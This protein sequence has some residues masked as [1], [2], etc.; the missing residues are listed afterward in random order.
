MLKIKSCFQ[1]MKLF[2][3]YILDNK[4]SVQISTN[5]MIHISCSLFSMIQLTNWRLYNLETISVPCNTSISIYL[6]DE[7]CWVHIKKPTW[8]NM[9]VEVQF[10]Y[11]EPAF[12]VLYPATKLTY[13]IFLRSKLNACVISKTAIVTVKKKTHCFK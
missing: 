10:L 6:W 5:L 9:A 8:L 7:I 3:I 2:I 4:V 1:L 12:F 13:Y 11:R